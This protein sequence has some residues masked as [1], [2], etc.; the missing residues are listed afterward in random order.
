MVRA[1]VDGL[2]LGP[3][4]TDDVWDRRSCRSARRRSPVD[5]RRPPRPSGTSPHALRAGW[6]EP[7]TLRDR[8]D[9]HQNDLV[10]AYDTAV[11]PGR[12]RM[13]RR[14]THRRLRHGVALAVLFHW[15]R[16]A[17]PVSHQHLL[18]GSRITRRFPVAA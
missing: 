1:L 18:A 3:W 16:A 4:E 2:G 8:L 13:A 9:P 6:D 11:T 14:G 12:R 10:A 5:P 15:N 17:M 7:D